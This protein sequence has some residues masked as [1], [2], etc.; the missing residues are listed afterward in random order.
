M[1]VQGGRPHWTLGGQD[2]EHTLGRETTVNAVFTNDG[3]MCMK[4]IKTLTRKSVVHGY[5]NPHGYQPPQLTRG[6]TWH[7]HKACTFHV[8]YMK[9]LNYM[10]RK[11]VAMVEGANILR[12]WNVP[13]ML[14]T[15]KHVIIKGWGGQV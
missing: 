1:F 8:Q 9:K 13:S 12:P 7:M 3:G 15:P 6:C 2:G 11:S 4:D 10:P 14:P 5:M